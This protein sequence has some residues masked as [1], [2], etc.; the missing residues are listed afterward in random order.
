MYSIIY[1]INRIK[2]IS[3]LYLLLYTSVSI[4]Q[5]KTDLEKFIE[6]G[7]FRTRSI[8]LVLT[9][10]I[11]NCF[12]EVVKTTKLYLIF[13]S[14]DAQGNLVKKSYY[15]FEGD[16]SF[17]RNYKYDNH[18]NLIETSRYNSE[19]S[20]DCQYKYDAQGNLI[21]ES[22]YYS[23]RSALIIKYKHGFDENG[24]P[25]ETISTTLIE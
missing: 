4:S 5:D 20:L 22:I 8:T 12:I 24:N 1:T 16:L 21:Q 25:I 7:D 2:I 10:N 6:K 18:G 19:G 14:F 9:K 13:S 15:N 17:Q 11:D 23:A 3:L